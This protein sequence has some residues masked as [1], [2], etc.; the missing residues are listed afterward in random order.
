MRVHA[1]QFLNGRLPDIQAD[2]LSRA[3]EVHSHAT[4]AAGRGLYKATRDHRAIAY[5]VPNEWA[6]VPD[7]VRGAKSLAAFKKQS[8]SIFINQY[9]SFRCYV[10]GCWEC[11]HEG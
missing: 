11:E 1:W 5:R 3:T 4:R 2:M 10:R 6:S 9:K 8:K 7:K